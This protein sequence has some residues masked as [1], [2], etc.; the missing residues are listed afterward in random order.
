VTN[1]LSVK[2]L[3]A[4][5]AYLTAPTFLASA[6]NQAS[7]HVLAPAQNG[8]EPQNLG[9]TESEPLAPTARVEVVFNNGSVT[10]VAVGAATTIQPSNDTVSP[11]FI[12][13]S[14]CT[15]PGIVRADYTIKTQ[16]GDI[17][18]SAVRS[19]GACDSLSV[20]YTFK[21]AGDYPITMIVTDENNLTATAS[22]TLTVLDG[23]KNDGGFTIAAVPMLTQPTKPIAFTSYCFMPSGFT[24]AW[25]FG[26][27]ATAGGISA[28]HA[29]GQI[30]QYTARATCT[31]ADTKIVKTAWVS[32]V[33]TTAEL[34]LPPVQYT[35][36]LG[37][38][39]GP[40]QSPVQSPGPKPVLF[41]NQSPL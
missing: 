7:Y 4:L 37:L 17:P 10:T 12:A 20:P 3:I 21:T 36:P 34:A 30:G 28:T 2:K 22:M 29:Y 40:N 31:S 25:D 26:D 11:N 6:C 38:P 5:M 1:T 41:P 23:S 19:P 35:A 13:T 15:N 24:V 18:V 9:N 32:I 27:G 33:I 8:I 16:T 39:P 14:S